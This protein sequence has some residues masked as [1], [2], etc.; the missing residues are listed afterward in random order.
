[1]ARASEVVV[2]ATI[3]DYEFS[4]TPE[5]IIIAVDELTLAHVCSDELPYPVSFTFHRLVPLQKGCTVEKL[6][7]DHGSTCD[8]IYLPPGEYEVEICDDG[9][10]K[11]TPDGVYPISLVL[12]P[13]TAAHTIAEQLN[14]NM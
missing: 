14:N 4:V 3:Q 11:F 10:A 8:R 9:G 1:M 2:Q 13:V 7:S 12:E 5:E 6:C